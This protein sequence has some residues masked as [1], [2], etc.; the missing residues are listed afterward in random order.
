VK[1]RKISAV[2]LGASAGGV[3]AL[4]SLLP[5]F[6][7]SCDVPVLVV[8]HLPRERPSRLVELFGPK[9]RVRVSEAEDKEPI[10]SGCV[11]FAPPDYH[12]LVDEGPTLS[13][14][15]DELRHFS[16]PSIDA[17]FE[18]A[19]DVYGAGLL[20]VVLTGANADGAEGLAAVARAGGLTVV[21]LPASASVATMPE[22]AL[23]AVPNSL[24]LDLSEIAALL[25]GIDEGRL[26]SDI[27]ARSCE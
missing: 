19:A 14:S 12:L 23:K 26:T 15:S 7:R 3:E 16:R 8:V 9:C 18:S 1:G 4:L 21:Q 11:Y 2:V 24:Q 13:L 25:R 5:A 10:G 6:E 20:A 22:A 27:P 17:L